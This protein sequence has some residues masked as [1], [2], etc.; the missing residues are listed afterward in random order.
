MIAVQYF[1]ENSTP[2][3]VLG[4]I[5]LT[6]TGIAY[7][8][9]RRGAALG[10]M[11]AVAVLTGLGLLAERL[12]VTP[13]EEV[14]ATLL[15][16]L[17][18]AEANDLPGVL[19]MVDTNSASIYADAEALMPKFLIHK[20]GANGEIEVLIDA[21]KPSPEATANFKFAVNVTHR[22]SGVKAPYFDDVTLMLRKRGDDWVIT[23]YSASKNWRADAARL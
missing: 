8:H 23:D 13:R 2:V 6:M 16:L 1:A 15:T 10:A 19:A 11:L 20:A 12:I 14:Q 9:T 18:R 17:D 7:V 21:D 3:W 5:L 22:E 4:A